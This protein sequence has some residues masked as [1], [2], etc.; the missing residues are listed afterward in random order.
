MAIVSVRDFGHSDRSR[1][2]SKKLLP[3]ISDYCSPGIP[4][5]LPHLSE[6][7]PFP[8]PN[9][10]QERRGHARKQGAYPIVHSHT[11]TP[12]TQSTPPQSPRQ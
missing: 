6:D 12:L 2:M 5:G 11:Y 10:H 1:L 7:S 4:N 3:M 9:M 8:Q